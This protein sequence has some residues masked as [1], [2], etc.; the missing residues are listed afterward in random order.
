[1]CSP[2]E[3]QPARSGDAG[4]RTERIENC[5]ASF[6]RYLYTEVGRAFRWVDRLG[7][8]DDEISAYL[9]DPRI[10]LWVM[11]V[12]GT[13]AGY[14]ELRHGGDESVEIAYFGLLPDHLGRGLG[15]HLLSDAAERAWASGARRVWLQTCSLDHPAALPNYLARGFK[16]FR[17]ERFVVPA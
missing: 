3:L 10:E 7:W 5:P 14:F 4:V 13:P 6:W 2:L 11:T 8:T 9:S 17:T 15:K 16:I 12:G 1:M